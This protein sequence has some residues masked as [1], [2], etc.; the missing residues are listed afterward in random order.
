MARRWKCS[1]SLVTVITGCAEPW[2]SNHSLCKC[3]DARERGSLLRGF[4]ALYSAVYCVIELS[5]NNLH[6]L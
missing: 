2:G 5:A 1:S 4:V 6:C 3:L